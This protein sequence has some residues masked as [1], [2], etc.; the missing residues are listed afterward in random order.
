MKIPSKVDNLTMEMYIKLLKIEELEI[1]ETAVENVEVERSEMIVSLLTGL[2]REQINDLPLWR[3]EAYF[4]EISYL[5]NSKPTNKIKKTLFIN[6]KRYRVC[7]SEKDMNANQFTITETLREDSINNLN[8]LGAVIYMRHQ[9]FKKPMF[10]ESG[11]SF[12]SKEI[13]K[14]KVKN[15]YGALFFYSVRLNL[16][17]PIF[18]TYSQKEMR[19]VRERIR[20]IESRLMV[21]KTNTV[22][23][24]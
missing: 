13:L 5:R 11:F 4:R 21:L 7:R 24:T 23:T 16:S 20:Q 2:T 6:G 19:L 14:Q 9:Y 3:T 15:V 8:R 1:D 18:L 10:T 12:L 17:N 22:G